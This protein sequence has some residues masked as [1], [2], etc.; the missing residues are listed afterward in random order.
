M[1]LMNLRGRI[2]DWPVKTKVSSVIYAVSIVV[3]LTATSA[4]FTAQM[5]ITRTAFQ[6]DVEA[7]A[8]I[9]SDNCAAPLAFNDETVARQT[10][11]SLSAK[12]EI[13]YAAV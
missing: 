6:H 13:V 3:L 9:I 5:H 7:L 11:A 4:L 1:I 2:S 10:L 8:A 12:A